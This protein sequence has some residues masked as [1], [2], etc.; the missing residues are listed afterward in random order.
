MCSAVSRATLSIG[1]VARRS[2]FAP[3]ALRYYESIGLLPP[4]ERVNGRRRYA[5]QALD[6]VE[7]VRAA[8][9]AGFTLREIGAL[10]DS[11]PARTPLSERWRVLAREKREQLE[12]QARQIEVMRELLGHLE[13]CD[14]DDEAQCAAAVREAVARG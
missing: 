3:S 12:R 14:C 11:F 6:R 8:Q 2:G 13:G 9:A 1:E 7:L 5:E 10:F 4:T